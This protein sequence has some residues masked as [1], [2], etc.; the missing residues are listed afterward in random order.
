MSNVAGRPN[1]RYEVLDEDGTFSD[2][3]YRFM[4]QIWVR[5]GGSVDGIDELTQA[6]ELV[7]TIPRTEQEKP[8]DNLTPAS[9]QIAPENNLTPVSLRIAQEDNLTPFAIEKRDDTLADLAPL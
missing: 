3:W 6:L 2:F 4:E 7:E 5:S 8:D 9:T 1:K